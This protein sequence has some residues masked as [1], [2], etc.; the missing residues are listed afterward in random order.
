MSDDVQTIKAKIESLTAEK[1]EAQAALNKARKAKQEVES[2]LQTYGAK[3]DVGQRTT[4]AANLEE[5]RQTIKKL[6]RKIENVTAK[7][8]AQ[9]ELLA[10]ALQVEAADARANAA[11]EQAAAEAAAE[12]EH[13]AAAEV[14]PDS[15]KRAGHNRDL[16]DAQRRR[17]ARQREAADLAAQAASLAEQ[18]VTRAAAIDE[19]PDEDQPEPEPENARPRRGIGLGGLALFLGLGALLLSRR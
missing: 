11:Q 4:A 3:M 18:V 9:Q 6:R 5:L 10:L 2:D 16:R 1:A 8:K 15:G 12:V 13:A 17:A 19:E 14:E 7:I